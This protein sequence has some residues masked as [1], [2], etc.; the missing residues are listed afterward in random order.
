MPPTQRRESPEWMPFVSRLS[1]ELR[2]HLTANLGYG[3]LLREEAQRT[4]RFD[5]AR[6]VERLLASGRAALE[7]VE[8]TVALIRL[9]EGQVSP[10]YSHFRVGTL[11]HEV[12]SHLRP[13][14]ASQSTLL[15]L[16]QDE[17]RLGAADTDRDWLRHVIWNLVA[18]A[19]RA[20]PG[21]RVELQ[22]TRVEGSPDVL[23]LVVRDDGPPLTPDQLEQIFAVPAEQ[24]APDSE[25][26]GSSLG[27]VLARRFTRELGGRLS[28][29]AGGE[30]TQLTLEVPLTR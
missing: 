4:E 18:R 30:G 5:D 27:L 19:A 23:R 1:L 26:P 8:D 21:G 24:S 14:A 17:A 25:G 22:A 11:L 7:L 16:D 29:H 12:V 20:C 13:M 9:E 15:H 3:E 10:T 2:T 6:D 28:A